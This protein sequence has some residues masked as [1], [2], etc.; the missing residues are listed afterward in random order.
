MAKAENGKSNPGQR[1]GMSSL[2]CRRS[3]P[4]SVGARAVHIALFPKIQPAQIKQ[5]DHH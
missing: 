5:A 1:A 3:F 4:E 2:R